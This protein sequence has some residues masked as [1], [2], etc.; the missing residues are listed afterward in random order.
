MDEEERAAIVTTFKCRLFDDLLILLDEVFR[1]FEVGVMFS[2]N[3]PAI[4]RR[5][6]GYARQ[7]EKEHDKKTQ[8]FCANKTD[9]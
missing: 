4:R 6:L 5:R 1:I 7:N 3:C 8:W 2:R 9:V